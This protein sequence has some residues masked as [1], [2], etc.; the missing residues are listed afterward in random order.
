MIKYKQVDELNDIS[1][2]VIT[3]ITVSDT[4][5]IMTRT[6]NQ[7]YSFN[8]KYGNH[9]IIQ[10]SQEGEQ[11]IRGE[12]AYDI[13]VRHGFNGNPRQWLNSLKGERGDSGQDGIQ[14]QNGINGIDGVM[15][16]LTLGSLSYSDNLE[17]EYNIVQENDS[18]KLNLSIPLKAAGARGK[19]APLP[20]LQLGSVVLSNIYNEQAEASLIKEDNTYILNLV[21]PKGEHGDGATPAFGIRA[22]PP[23]IQ[24]EVEYIDNGLR[25]NVHRSRI[26]ENT[27]LF[28]LEIPRGPS[29]S[30]IIVGEQGTKGTYGGLSA[31]KVQRYPYVDYPGKGFSAIT[32]AIDNSDAYGWSW[33]LNSGEI[34]QLIHTENHVFWRKG[35]NHSI[36]GVDWIRR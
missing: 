7:Q 4:T 1:Q 6:D 12:S 13:A 25:P 19:D 2:H 32:L 28:K 34:F 20:E 31:F 27:L 18:Y 23:E 36:V 15:P 8:L 29:N 35:N 16:V 21:I 30:D 24:L 10:E 17:P 14:Q 5:I 3:D 22:I 26:D 9:Y 11:G 33:H